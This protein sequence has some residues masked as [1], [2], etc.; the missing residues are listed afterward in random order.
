MRS[1][2]AS[3]QIMQVPTLF[4]LTALGTVACGSGAS[5]PTGAASGPSDGADSGGGEPTNPCGLHTIYDG[6]EN[7]ILP[8][9]PEDGLQLHVGPSSYD[10]PDVIN[11][12]G[13]DGK[14]LWLMEPGDERTNCFHMVTPN[15]TGVYYFKQQYRMRTGSH[16]MIVSNSTNTSTTAEWTPCQGG[17][18][19]AIGGTQHVIEDLPP[20]GNVAPED[21][22]LGRGLDPHSPIDIQLHFY[23]T[24]DKPRLREVWVNWLYKPKAEVTT[25]LGMLG[26]FVTKRDPV[27]GQRLPLVLAHTQATIGNV[28]TAEQA[29]PA[30]TSAAPARIVTLFGHAHTHNTRFVVY[31]DKADGSSDVVYDS[32]D[33]AEAPTY[34]YDTLVQ[35]PVADPVNRK[36]GGSSGLLLLAPGDQLRFSCDINND[37]DFDFMGQNE[38]NTDEMCNLFGSVAGAGFPCFDLSKYTPPKPPAMP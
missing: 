15:D 22:G 24:T 25:N 2:F 11:A 14:P 23:N 7:C 27:T 32:Y 17:I 13:A 30:A 29:I 8:P 37:T 4:L 26:G 28:C 9:A 33:G 10:D 31:K 35:N 6:D 20:G 1:I 19:G 18:V 5:T 21:E 12:V 36:S 16:H 38:V 34:T 3:I